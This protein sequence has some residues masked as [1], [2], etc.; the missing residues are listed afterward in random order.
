MSAFL[1]PIHTWIFSKILLAEDLES[2]LKKVYIDKY[3][4][5]AKD[6][7]EKSL[8]YGSPID[9][10]KSIEDIID[11]SNIHGWLQDKIKKAETRIAFIIT[12]MT[13]KNE[14]EAEVIAH[15]CFV[16]Q[17]EIVGEISRAKEMSK[18]PE[19]VFNALNNY[20]LEGMPCDR[21]TRPIKSEDDIFEWETTS[22]IH[23]SY[24][25]TVEGDVNIFYNLRHEWIKAFVENSNGEY[26]Y[27]FIRNLKHNGIIGVNQIIRK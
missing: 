18:N 11:V 27:N 12:E 8:V 25:E 10:S 4:D 6:V 19:D 15:E 9:T 7:I 23:K 20:L 3:G 14:T 22:C 5:N 2:N 17:G 24:W 1:A 26:T 13:K 21:V 16:K